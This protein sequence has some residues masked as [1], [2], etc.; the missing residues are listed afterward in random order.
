M[1]S[2]Q[3]MT[4][5]TEADH[6][7]L[8]PS[9]SSSNINVGAAERVASALAGGALAAYG[10]KNLFSP[11]GVFTILAGGM[12]LQRGLTGYCM[13][14]KAIGRNTNTGYDRKTEAVEV[15]ETLHIDKTPAE[16]YAFWRKLEN[17]PLFMKHLKKVEELDA[18]NSVW[19]AHV[20]GNLTT[21][22]WKAMIDEDIP[23][24]MISWSS[25]PGSTIDNAG[26][27]RFINSMGG[28]QLTVLMSYRL[29]AGELGSV[30]GKLVNPSVEKMI[31]EDLARF[32]SM[33]EAG[34]FTTIDDLSTPSLAVHTPTELVSG[35]QSDESPA[36]AS[37]EGRKGRGSRKKPDVTGNKPL[38]QSTHFPD[39]DAGKGYGDSF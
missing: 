2:E 21:I 7:V 25:L 14:N 5:T 1:Q 10:I 36:T 13:V 15:Y 16:V 11:S 18:M 32:K 22:K 28:T 27:V 8:P 38:E 6:G 29:P 4:F 34:E 26:E 3:R 19:T 20:P 30:A 17:L 35:R 23:N 24:E 33:M 31:R 12:L 37:R 9:T 39:P